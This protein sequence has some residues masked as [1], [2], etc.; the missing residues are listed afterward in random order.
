MLSGRTRTHYVYIFLLFFSGRCRKGGLSLHAFTD[1]Q[2]KDAQFPF[3]FLS[4]SQYFPSIHIHPLTDAKTRMQSFPFFYFPSTNISFYSQKSTHG[5][6][7]KDAQFPFVLP[8]FNHYS[9]PFT[10]IHSHRE[11]RCTLFPCL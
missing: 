2:D 7:D 6:R 9:P 10:K 4:F 8:S 1:A 3:V 11:R 5:R